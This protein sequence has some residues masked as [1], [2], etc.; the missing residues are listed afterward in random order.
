MKKLLFIIGLSMFLGSSLIAGTVN[1]SFARDSLS[2]NPC[3]I[4]SSVQFIMV[5]SATGYMASDS[6]ELFAAF[7]DGTDTVFKAPI[8][9]SNFWEDFYHTYTMPGV[10][11]VQYIATGPDGAR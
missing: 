6:V 1:L 2:N 5:G 11:T 7:G 8:F 10:Y 9:N 4:P 3:Q